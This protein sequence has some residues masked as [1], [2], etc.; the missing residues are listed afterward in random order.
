MYTRTHVSPGIPNVMWNCLWRTQVMNSCNCACLVEITYMF[1]CRDR[2]SPLL[3]QLAAGAVVDADILAAV[4]GVLHAS[5][6]VRAAALG[7]LP[8]LPAFAAGQVPV[9]Q[10]GT[11]ELVGG[12]VQLYLHQ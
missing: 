6:A 8:S 5:P 12:E 2:V 10:A 7:A 3:K 11:D 1:A 9:L 4:K